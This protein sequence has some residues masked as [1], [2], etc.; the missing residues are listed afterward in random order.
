MFM[1]G[2]ESGACAW[3]EK[4]LRIGGSDLKGAWVVEIDNRSEEGVDWEGDG[5]CQGTKG[6]T[7]TL[8]AWEG[9]GGFSVKWRVGEVFV[10]DSRDVK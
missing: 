9:W 10:V 7:G 1:I 8:I 4:D 6:K 5:I 2:G 3:Q